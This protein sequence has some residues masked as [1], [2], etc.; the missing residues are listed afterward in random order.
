MSGADLFLELESLSR[1]L[2]RYAT[3]V[4]LIDLARSRIARFSMNSSV[5]AISSLEST[6]SVKRY[7][8][9]E[10]RARAIILSF[11]FSP[12]L[13]FSASLAHNSSQ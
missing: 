1:S 13:S 2:K 9:S 10:S 8:I 4:S 5:F 11:K 3:E 7:Q 6:Y 12:C